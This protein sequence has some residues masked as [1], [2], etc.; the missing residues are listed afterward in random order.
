MDETT[1]LQKDY[2]LKIRYLSDHLQRMWTRFNFFVTIESALVSGKFLI[3]SNVPSVALTVT[4]IVLSLI[5][6]VMGAQ[7]RFLVELYRTEVQTTGT[8]YAHAARGE[9]LAKAYNYVGRTD[10]DYVGAYREQQAVKRRHWGAM[11]RW[12]NQ[13]SSWRSESFSTTH[14]AAFI[15]LLATILWVVLLVVQF[16]P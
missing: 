4:G 8:Q 5:W 13:L 6:Y 1:F 11:R 14:L 15:P 10:D 2:E 7:D 16:I 3:A 9:T 12:F